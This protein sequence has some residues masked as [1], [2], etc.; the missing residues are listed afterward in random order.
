MSHW[1]MLTVVQ[2][3]SREEPSPWEG[4]AEEVAGAPALL[5]L[6]FFAALSTVELAA[7]SQVCLSLSFPILLSLSLFEAGST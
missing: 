1:E 3:R 5:P 4:K 7:R 2:E 6:S